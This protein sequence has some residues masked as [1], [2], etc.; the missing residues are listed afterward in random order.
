VPR[1][2]H[3]GRL[4]ISDRSTPQPTAVL[5]GAPAFGVPNSPCD[6]D[7]AL[8]TEMP[9][10]TVWKV[11]GGCEGGAYTPPHGEQEIPYGSVRRRM[12]LPQSASSRARRQDGDVLGCPAYYGGSSTSSSVGFLFG[13]TPP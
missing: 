8:F 12:A 9:R 2:K 5:I 3:G 4:L 10:E 7:Q 6:R 1:F 11:L 13:I